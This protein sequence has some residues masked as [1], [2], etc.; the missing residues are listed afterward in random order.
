MQFYLSIGFS[1]SFGYSLKSAVPLSQGMWRFLDLCQVSWSGVPF[2]RSKAGTVAWIPGSR[3]VPLLARESCSWRCPP[4]LLMPPAPPHHPDSSVT[5]PWGLQ[6]CLRSPKDGLVRSPCSAPLSPP[7]QLAS[8]GIPG[9]LLPASS[10]P[11]PVGHL[12]GPSPSSPLDGDSAILLCLPVP[13]PPTSSIP[14]AELGKGRP[15]IA[16]CAPVDVWTPS[17]LGSWGCLAVLSLVPHQLLF[18]SPSAALLDLGRCHRASSPH[19]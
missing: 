16:V 18:T 5:P 8:L 3:M 1:F 7:P 4:G 10:R 19:A 6:N 13:R 11:S 17:Q 15:L 12:H 9:P 14:V 2:Q